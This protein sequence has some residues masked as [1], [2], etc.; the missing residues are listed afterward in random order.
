[1]D[2]VVV[3]ARPDWCQEGDD[4]IAGEDNEG[5]EFSKGKGPVGKKTRKKGIQYEV[6]V[7]PY[8]CVYTA[9]CP[10]LFFLS[11]QNAKF[12]EGVS[13]VTVVGSPKREEIQQQC[14]YI[15]KWEG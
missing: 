14:Q 2:S 8:C 3:P 11:F 4:P 15:L 13:G 10:Q 7:V 9:S 1:M 6:P 12:V 5:K